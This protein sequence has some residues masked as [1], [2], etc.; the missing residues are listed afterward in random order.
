MGKRIFSTVTLW[1]VVFGCIYFFGST[2][3][4]WLITLI[5]ALTLREFYALVR[6]M[7]QPPF[8]NTGIAFSVAITLAPLYLE[9][10]PALRAFGSQTTLVLIGLATVAFAIRILRERTAELRVETLAWSLFGVIYVP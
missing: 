2:G 7:G 3:G 4:V 1:A 5:A 9:T 10:L 8:A 6:K